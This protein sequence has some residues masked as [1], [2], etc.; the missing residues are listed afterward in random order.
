LSY[1]NGA[2]VILKYLRVREMTLKRYQLVV[3]NEL[4]IKN[5]TRP[6]GKFHMHSISLINAPALHKMLYK[7]TAHKRKKV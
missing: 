4:D 2:V 6:G 5:L 3:Q 7:R 1:V